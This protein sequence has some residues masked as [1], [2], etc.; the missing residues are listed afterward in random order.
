M[1]SSSEAFIFLGV[2]AVLFAAAIQQ[3]IPSPP[4]TCVGIDLGTTF[5]CI[6]VFEDGDVTVI[7]NRAKSSITP[8]VIFQPA[9]GSAPLVV[10][11][12][13]RATAAVAPGTL[14]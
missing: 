11:E 7:N 4:V 13:A 12:G 9:D 2:L 8:S 6:A 14:V 5:S 1:D 10:G 3:M